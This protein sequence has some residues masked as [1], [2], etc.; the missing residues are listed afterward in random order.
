MV[1]FGDLKRDRGFE[2]IPKQTD[3]MTALDAEFEVLTDRSFLRI[4]VL[5]PMSP[6]GR[7]HDLVEHAV[8]RLDATVSENENPFAQIVLLCPNLKRPAPDLQ[9]L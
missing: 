7:I 6:S 8:G 3:P 2:I 1:E 4:L 9:L 5:G